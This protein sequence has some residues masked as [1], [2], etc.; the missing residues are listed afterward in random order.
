MTVWSRLVKRVANIVI[1][2]FMEN[3]E[4]QI[5]SEIKALMS[6]VRLQLE[7]LDMKMAELQQVYDPQ[8]VEVEEIDLEFD[9][10]EMAFAAAEVAV[11]A[12]SDMP[13]DIDEE[14]VAPASEEPVEDDSEE[15]VSAEENIE[16]QP[17]EPV[18]DVDD[19]PFYDAPDVDLDES[20]AVEIVDELD[21][22]PDVELDELQNAPIEDELDVVIDEQEDVVEIVEVPEAVDV[23]ES[24]DVSE[25]V[26]APEVIEDVDLPEEEDLPLFAVEE[27]A[28]VTLL[29][30]AMA[31]SSKSAVIDVMTAKQ[32]WRTDIPGSPVKDIRAAIALVDRA[33]FINKLFAE[34][35]EAF[36][37]TINAVNQMSTLDE[38]VEY[39]ASAH[40]SWNFESD[41]VYRFMMAIRRKV[42]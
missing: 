1:N 11:A 32:A 35:P 31:A 39:L 33:L 25:T 30:T 36:M 29:E 38:A 14:C 27:E 4:Q 16:E 18:E 9:M 22:I 28:P 12:S 41:I 5:L 2:L 7:Q 26:E 34:N 13:E 20:E 21:D 23:P 40:P 10:P 6:S 19:L 8:S 42:N 37:A 3:R 24:V 15:S 17:V